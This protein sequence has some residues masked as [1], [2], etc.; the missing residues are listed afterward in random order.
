MKAQFKLAA[1]PTLVT[2]W[3]A[4]QGIGGIDWRVAYNWCLGLVAA[5][6]MFWWAVMYALFPRL[7]FGSKAG[8]IARMHEDLTES[9]RK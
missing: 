4:A 9:D 3:W 5:T 7:K 1:L 6:W 2:C 8:A